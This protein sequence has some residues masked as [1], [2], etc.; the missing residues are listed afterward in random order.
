MNLMLPM[1]IICHTDTHV[2][3]DTYLNIVTNAICFPLPACA[4]T[5]PQPG[6]AERQK[7]VP[8]QPLAAAHR[9]HEP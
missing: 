7:N 9:Q 6:A 8:D 3:L 2:A 4:P 5:V 1:L